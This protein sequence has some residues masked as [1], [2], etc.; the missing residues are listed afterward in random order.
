MPERRWLIVY[1]SCV[2]SPKDRR[3]L[4]FIIPTNFKENRPSLE[5]KISSAFQLPEFCKNTRFT[6]VYKPAILVPI[7][8]HINSVHTTN[9]YFFKN[10][11]TIVLYTP[12]PS[13]NLP[14]FLLS[15]TRYTCLTHQILFDLITP[16]IGVEE[17][18]P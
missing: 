14:A 15:R 2:T 17:D 18:K 10:C 16:I 5:S 12:R 11:F 13:K 4:F 1:Q 3:C 7:L 6:S 8:S 9:S